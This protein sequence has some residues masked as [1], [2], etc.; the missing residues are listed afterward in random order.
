MNY[1][2]AKGQGQRSLDSKASLGTDGRTDGGDR[3]TRSVKMVREFS[4]QSQQ[5]LY[6]LRAGVLVLYDREVL[7]SS[8]CFVGLLLTFCEH[9]AILVYRCGKNLC[10]Y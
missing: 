6:L 7:V 1:T 10:I 5:R 9:T 4:T 8:T 2:R 3:N